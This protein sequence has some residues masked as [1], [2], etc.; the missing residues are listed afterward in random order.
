MGKPRVT[1]TDLKTGKMEVL[2]EA[3]EGKPLARAE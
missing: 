2:A 3:Y 1:R